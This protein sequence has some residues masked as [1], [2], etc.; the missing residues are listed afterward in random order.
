MTLRKIIEYLFYGIIFLLPWQVAWL[1][2]EPFMGGFKWEYGTIGLYGVDIFIILF[3]VLSLVEYCRGFNFQFPISKFQSILNDSISK[4]KKDTFYQLLVTSYGLLAWS[5]VSI[6]WSPDKIL[7]L[8]FSL[9]LSLAVG[10]FWMARRIDF[11]W[12]KMIFVLLVAGALQGALGTGQFLAQETFSS[13]WLGT[14]QHLPQ[15]GGAS[16]VE[17][18]SGRWLRAYG[19]FAH[20]NILG[21]YLAIILLIVI[22]QKS[23]EF[24]TKKG[25]MLYALCSMIIFSGLILSFS[26]SAW[27]VFA[28]GFAILFLM[29]KERRKELGKIAIILAGVALIWIS[30]FSPLFFSRL[31]GQTRLEQKSLNDRQEYVMQAKEVISEN[32]WLGVGAGNY[33]AEIA[34]RNPE[35]QIWQIQPVHNVFLLI[36]SE[37]GMIG[38]LLFVALLLGIFI[39]GYKKNKALVLLLCV[40]YSMLGVVDHWLWTSHFGILFLFFVLGSIIHKK[41]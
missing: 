19:A 17:N 5:F 38:L 10:L 11:N 4:F 31:E 6:A 12:N 28:T 32:F 1:W 25:S 9:K 35:H 33:T 40:P 26:R 13:K 36:W 29:Q 41:H 39:E 34:Q 20:P 30:A 24:C 16:V 22:W 7:A 3:L 15:E 18:S 23:K 21:G 2:R 8:Y 27:L 14:V 37:L